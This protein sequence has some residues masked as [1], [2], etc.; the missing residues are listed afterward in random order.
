LRRDSIQ[1]NGDRGTVLDAV[2]DDLSWDALLDAR[3][4][5]TSPRAAGGGRAG[6]IA[7]GR[8]SQAVLDFLSTVDV[9]RLVLAEED[10]GS[11]GS[12]W[13]IRERRYREEERRAEAEELSAGGCG[14]CPRL[15]SWRPRKRSTG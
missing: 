10:V 15:P 2:K 8:R 3:R 13:E 7:D 14:S 11:E 5:P 12:E 6:S 9:G 4:Q 1:F